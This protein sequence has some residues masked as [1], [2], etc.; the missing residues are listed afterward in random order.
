MSIKPV[1]SDSRLLREFK[2]LVYL[3]CID[4][5]YLHLKKIKVKLG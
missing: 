1:I 3:N 5:L 2:T 4:V